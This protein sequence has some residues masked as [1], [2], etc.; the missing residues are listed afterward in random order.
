MPNRYDTDYKIGQDNIRTWGMDVHNPVFVIS[1]LLVLL[2]VIGTLMFPGDAKLA[3][4]GAK[5]WSINNFDWFFLV[6]GNFF[7]IFCLF[8]VV[9]PVGKIRLGGVKARPEFSTL[10]WFAML[11]AAGMGIGL[12]FFSVAEPTAHFT[13]WWGTP[14]N[15]AE[16]TPQGGT[17]GN[18]RNHVSLGAAPVG[19]LC[20]SRSV[21]GIFHV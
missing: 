13:N 9:L 7:V 6:A 3:F 2:F 21:T 11:F 15:V 10:S 20:G 1:A 18:G 16:R 17:V 4:D 8:L 19:D 12:M 5:G 14:L